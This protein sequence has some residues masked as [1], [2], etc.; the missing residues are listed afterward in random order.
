MNSL[1]KHEPP[2]LQSTVLGSLT[3]ATVESQNQLIECRQIV[4]TFLCIRTPM[5]TD[6]L[7]SMIVA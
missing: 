7:V 6:Q 3:S 5:D 4:W 1:S 2:A